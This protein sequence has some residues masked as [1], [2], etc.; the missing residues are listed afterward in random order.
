MKILHVLIVK[1]SGH[2][3]NVCPTARK[4]QYDNNN[5]NYNNNYKS[6]NYNE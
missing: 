1:V 6:K 4:R 2:R 3:S 5:N